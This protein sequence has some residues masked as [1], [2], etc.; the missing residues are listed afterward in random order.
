MGFSFKT[1]TAETL[2]SSDLN[3]Q[4]TKVEN[5]LGNIVSSDV[6]ENAS[7]TS[8]QLQ[9]RYTTCFQTI[10][11]LGVN[12]AAATHIWM[13]PDTAGTGAIIIP[14]NVQDSTG[15]GLRFDPMFPG[16]RA[17]LVAV[18]AR[19]DGYTRAGGTDD[20][21]IHVLHNNVLISSIDVTADATYFI[22]AGAG[23][24]AFASPI[25]AMQDTD[26]LEVKLGNQVNNETPEVRSIVITFVYKVELTS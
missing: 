18:T 21:S 20:M 26:Y 8:Q 25:A 15:T 1:W 19:V 4:F 17:Y 22:R 9:D 6:A 5:K 11:L 14:E 23:S 24:I 16:K 3:A 10:P 13:D 7:L 2:T 12:T